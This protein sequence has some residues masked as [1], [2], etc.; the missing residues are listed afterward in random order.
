VV[1]IVGAVSINV[2]GEALRP[3]ELFKWIIIPLILIFV[4]IFRPYGLISF[5]EINA[6]RLLRPKNKRDL[7]NTDIAKSKLGV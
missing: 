6:K 4:M 7:M 5:K 2:L 3:L 1:S